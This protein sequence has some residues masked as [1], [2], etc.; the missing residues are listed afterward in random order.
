MAVATLYL[1]GGMAD[2]E[3]VLELLGDAGKQTI[4]GRG[5]W[6][7]QVHRQGGFGRA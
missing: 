6:F 1:D 7:D 3:S 2:M 4:G 5:V